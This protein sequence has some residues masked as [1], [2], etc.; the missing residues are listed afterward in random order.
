MGGVM[1]RRLR[2]VVVVAVVVFGVSC[3]GQGAGDAEAVV[4]AEGS[5]VLPFSS[6]QDWVSYSD[7]VVVAEVESQGEVPPSERE[8]EIGE[9]MIVR[10]V[11][12]RVTE[13]L[14][15][16]PDAPVPP[17]TLTFTTAGWVFKGEKRSRMV[18][19]D[20]AWLE[21]GRSYAMPVA[22]FRSRPGVDWAP[23]SVEA[24]YPVEGGL[25]RGPEGGE[26]APVVK[27]LSGRSLE[28]VRAILQGAEADPRAVARGD[29]DPVERFQAVQAEEAGEREP[30][31]GPGEVVDPGP[32]PDPVPPGPEDQ[33]GTDG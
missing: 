21:V 13:T 30:Q 2:V 9:G 22:L 25:L 10:T 33:S 29:L 5:G 17:E 12:V 7:A 27:A 26:Q 3:A 23:I 19:G 15:S 16:R 4:R 1:G 6:L 8:L 28:Q 18:F 11:T 32:A 20:G 31:P 14:W 24:V